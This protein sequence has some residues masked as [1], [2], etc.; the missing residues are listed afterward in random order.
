M[1]LVG[2]AGLASDQ[3]MLIVEH[4]G[5]PQR[6]IEET[7]QTSKAFFDLPVGRKE[8]WGSGIQAPDRKLPYPGRKWL[9]KRGVHHCTYVSH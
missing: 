4:T 1:A 9:R 8:R 5:V 6:T 2:D 7:V 3:G